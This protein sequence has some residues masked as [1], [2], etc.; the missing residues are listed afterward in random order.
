MSGRRTVTEEAL[1][2]S[3]QFGNIPHI[4]PTTWWMQFVKSAIDDA[5]SGT[6]AEIPRINIPNS[7][8]KFKLNR[9]RVNASPIWSKKA[10]AN[11]S[12]TP[13]AELW[14]DSSYGNR[15]FWGKLYD[16]KTGKEITSNI[17]VN[18]NIGILIRTGKFKFYED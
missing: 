11:T 17:V 6:P 18:K 10:T 7:S 14:D 9:P 12:L 1:S 15:R 4:P 13:F 5:I 2:E 8:I 3:Y 16:P